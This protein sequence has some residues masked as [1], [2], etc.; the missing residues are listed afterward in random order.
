MAVSRMHAWRRALIVVPLII[1]LA[2]MTLGLSSC[3]SSGGKQ[4]SQEIQDN[5]NNSVDAIM[6]KY[7]IPGAIIGA[8]VP[9]QGEWVVTK[10]KADTKTG[11]APKLDDHVRIASITK[12]FTATVVLQLVGEGKLKLDDTLNKFDLGLAVPNSDKIT[13]RNLLNMTSG[14]F[15]YTADE[16]FWNTYT[17]DP[18]KPWTPKELV[19]ISI[20]HGAVAP[21]GGAY[22]YNNTNY[23]LLG[24]IIEKLTGSTA[25][26]EITTRIIDKLPL[27]NTTF[28]A[29]TAMPSPF[30]HGYTPNPDGEASAAATNDVSI[31]TPTAGWT[32]GAIISTQADIKRWLEALRSGEL[33]TPEMHKE[34]M[35]FGPPNTDNY[36]LGLMGFTSFIGHSG[37]I[38]GYN[39]AAYTQTKEDGVTIIVFINRYPNAIEGVPEEILGAIAKDLAPVIQK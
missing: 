7:K 9:G 37:E 35:T 10:G 39:N 18:K 15:S 20:K 31:S 27:K 22:D 14:L 36:G 21:P 26:K 25:G 17:H 19:D 33:L 34:Q 8:W 23:I 12:T 29:D 24:L 13:V 5:L 2:L 4:F 32:A 3:G 30:M 6:K 11:E 38:L 1:L 28:P 16:D